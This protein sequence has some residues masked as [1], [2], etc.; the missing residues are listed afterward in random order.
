MGWEPRAVPAGF[1]PMKAAL[2]LLALL[3]SA[4]APTVTADAPPPVAMSGWTPDTPLP[5]PEGDLAHIRAYAAANG[6]TY[7][8]DEERL[9]LLNQFRWRAER[10]APASFQMVYGDKGSLHVN[11][12]PPFDRARILALAA[13]ELR[14]HLAIHKVRQNAAEL[15]ETQAALNAALATLD[16][17]EWISTYDYKADRFAVELSG[18]ANRPRLEAVL[19]PDIAPY[20]VIRTSEGPLLVY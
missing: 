2:P 8:P 1:R 14:D 20:V 9:A 16:G 3:A 15:A 11:V 17:L 5:A 12:K 6:F 18:A 7:T 13:P 4:C 10:E 19:P